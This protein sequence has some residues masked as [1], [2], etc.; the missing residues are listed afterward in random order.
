[1]R[2]WDFIGTVDSWE[3][4]V[5]HCTQRGK[6]VQGDSLEILQPDG[7]VVAL[8]PEWIENEA[9]ERVDATPHPM[10]H[11]T[12]PCKTPLMPYSLLRMHKKEETA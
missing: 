7:S 1:M 6:F 2:E 8:T 10:M 3:D 4:G 5:A 11:Y 9:G 12:I